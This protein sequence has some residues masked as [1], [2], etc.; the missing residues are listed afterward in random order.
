MQLKLSIFFFLGFIF[1]IAGCSTTKLFYGYGDSIVSWQIDSY[2]E[3]TN[4]QEDW[5]EKQMR[6]HLEWHRNEELP[7]YKN[8]LIDVQNK[9]KDGLSMSELDEGFF[10]FESK[11]DRIFERLIPDAALFLT[12]I[13]PEQINNLEQEL[14]EENDEMKKKL[15]NRHE[16]LEERQEDFWEQMEDWFGDFSISQRDQITEIQTKWFTETPDPSAERMERRLKSQTKFLFLLRSSPEK[17]QVEK[18]FRKWTLS[19]QGSTDSARKVRILRNKKRIL[20]IDN[21]LTAENRLHAVQELD[22][23]LKNLEQIIGN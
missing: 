9:A 6:Q 11:I 14:A 13:S 23:W 10:R 12:K 8:F 5:V 16:L 1:F 3:L 20:Q 15:G 7:K 18:W 2:F 19:W 17:K 4:E 21:I 22:V